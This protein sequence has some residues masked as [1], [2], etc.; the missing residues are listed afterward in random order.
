[1][2]SKREG[3][4]AVVSLVLSGVRYSSFGFSFV[5]RH[6]TFDIFPMIRVESGYDVHRLARDEN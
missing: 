3:S 1:M 6:S 2:L 5:I 4:L